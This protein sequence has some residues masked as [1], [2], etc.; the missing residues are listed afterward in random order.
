MDADTVDLCSRVACSQ[1]PGAA[2][3][4]VPVSAMPTLSN[5]LILHAPLR[6]RRVSAP[7]GRRA[8]PTGGQAVAMIHRLRLSRGG[9]DGAAQPVE[10][11]H[12]LG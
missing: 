1:M 2:T 10:A 5:H 3:M 9:A 6:D 11:A 12:L 4:G 7:A 8:E